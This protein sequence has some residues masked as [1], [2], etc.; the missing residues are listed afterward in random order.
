MSVKRGK[1]NV[2]G[3]RGS[4]HR[5]GKVSKPQSAPTTDNARKRKREQD[6]SPI[7]ARSTRAEIPSTSCKRAR[8]QET[9]KRTTTRGACT[10]LQSCDLASSPVKKTYSEP[11]PLETPPLSQE[12]AVTSKLPSEL[13]ELL[14]LHSCFLTALFL[15]YAH[16]GPMIPVDVRILCPTI[17]RVW[18][19]R[20]VN[21]D[22][23]RRLLATQQTQSIQENKTPQNDFVLRDYG[24]GKTCIEVVE[25]TPQASASRPLDEKRLNDQFSQSLLRQWTAFQMETPA[26]FSVATFINSLPLY[27]IT[28]DTSADKLTLQ[29]SKGQIRLKD[30]KAG[31][32]KAQERALKDT[33]ANASPNPLQNP[34]IKDP[35]ARSA[36]LK[37]RIF[38]KQLQQVS[39]PTPLTPEQVARRH[40]LHRT[41]EVARVLESLIVAA[42]K[43]RNDDAGEMWAQTTRNFSFA[44]P[45]LVQNLQMSLRNPISRDEAINC[46]RVIGELAPE[47]VSVREVSKLIGVTIRGTGIKKVA[48]AARV[49]VALENL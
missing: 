32:I 1:T 25:L 34:M 38:A 35:F 46:V 36:D 45:A 26:P 24:N 9:V 48:L 37:S 8:V 49:E 29:R 40:A 28:P 19:R 42:Q 30:I 11:K 15:H 7:F 14:D 2:V 44:M 43:H 39:L 18:R 10:R 41:V 17:A 31:A 47:W 33:T 13:Q 27:P 4:I 21:L 6:E 3:Q 16:N 22:T 12:Q 20:G 23:V 5:F